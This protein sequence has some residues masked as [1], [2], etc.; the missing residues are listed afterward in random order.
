MLQI[1]APSTPTPR[2]IS[3]Q[4]SSR[5]N[6]KEKKEEVEHLT[7]DEDEHKSYIADD[8]QRNKGTKR[9]RNGSQEGDSGP[10]HEIRSQKKRRVT[11]QPGSSLDNP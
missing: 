11:N 1:V 9:P 7:L 8:L 3:P 10:A 6:Q 5:P 4:G 2:Q